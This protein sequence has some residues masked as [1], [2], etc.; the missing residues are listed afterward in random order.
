MNVTD[1]LRQQGRTQLL[2]IFRR[3]KGDKCLFFER[4]LHILLNVVLNDDDI[5]KERIEHVFLLENETEVNVSKLYNVSNILFFLRPHFYEIEN[6]FKLIERIAKSE[7]GKLGGG[8]G[9]GGKLGGEPPGGGRKYALVF[10]PYMTPMCQAEILKH[11]LLDIHIRVIV[12]PLYFFPLYNDVFSLEIKGLYKEYYVDSDFTS[13]LMCSFSLMFLQH[14]FDGVFKSIKSLGHLSHFI[15]EQLIQLRKEIVSM[16][17]DIQASNKFDEDFL[18]ILNNLQNMQDVRHFQDSGQPPVIPVKYALHKIFLSERARRRR[19]SSRSPSTRREPLDKG[20]QKRTTPGKTPPRENKNRG[21]KSQRGRGAEEED[22]AEQGGEDGDR[23]DDGGE[24]ADHSDGEG[25]SDNDGNRDDQDNQDHGH[26]AEGDPPGGSEGAPEEAAEKTLEGEEHT[27]VEWTRKRNEQSIKREMPSQGTLVET[28]AAPNEGVNT[29]SDSDRSGNSRGEGIKRRDT[30]NSGRDGN[31]SSSSFGRSGGKREEGMS[32]SGGHTEGEINRAVQE[33]RRKG[34]SRRRPSKGENKRVIKSLQRKKRRDSSEE[35]YL[36]DEEYESGSASTGPNFM[37][38]EDNT[39]FLL[40]RKDKQKMERRSKK[41]KSY[42]QEKLGVSNFNFLLNVST[43]IDSCVIIDRKIDMVT[44]FCTPFT[45]EGL[46]DHLFGI[47]NLQIEVPR[48]IIFNEMSNPGGE[49][50]GEAKW[51]RKEQESQHNS[52]VLKNM[53]VRIKLKNS[54]DVLYN[55]I[56]DLSPNKVGFYLHNKASEIQKTYKEKETL[57]DI[58]EI[59]TFLKK[60]KVK[61]YEHN[62]LSTHVNLAS[63]ILTTMKKEANFNKLKLED[64][65]IQLNSTSNRTILH[66]IVQQIQLLIYSNEDIYEVY[67]LLCLFSVVT[68]GFSETYTNELKK[69][70][71]E[72]YGIREL[73]RIN[74][75]HLC[76]ILKHQSKQKFIWSYL[77]NHFNLLSN[78]HNDI[79]YVC[80][81]YAPLSVRLIEYMGILKNNMQA[82]PEIFNLLSGPT[83]D[84]VQNAVGY[85]KFGVDDKG[86]KALWGGDPE[87]YKDIVLLFYVGGISYA[88]IAAIRN[89]NTHSRGYHYLIFT[90]EVISS[91]RLLQELAAP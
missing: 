14:L 24:D 17:F 19:T 27:P 30:S 53:M 46:L 78:E 75:L 63:F 77:R 32:P 57:K 48:Y 1:A 86:K 20:N 82:F 61:H 26:A 62:S 16:N 85:G 2:N 84:I 64:E 21:N 70:I 12:F 56:K 81:G 28:G 90:T 49:D 71:L 59:N 47:S 33:G 11:N 58:E 18:D 74:K 23:S 50:K 68:N 22:E 31:K 10:I 73:S 76:N 41:E 5:N 88:E 9:G 36:M 60:I 54:V 52:D 38:K 80:N 79:S 29:D 43:K 4:S 25:D 6:V 7:S 89:L 91:K 55:D 44:P 51:E 34:G 13:L 8:Q 65:I 67:R 3:F 87:G 39:N 35:A 69:D 42:L 66:N 72:N 45:Y 40:K 15:V 83:L 37:A